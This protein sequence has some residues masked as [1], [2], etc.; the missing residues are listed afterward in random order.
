MAEVATPSGHTGPADAGAK[1]K[2][3]TSKPER[4]DE[5]EY[6]KGLALKEKEH[7]AKQDALVRALKSS[8]SSSAH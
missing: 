7:K 2:S 6:K 5:E 8:T 4:P 1:S 3:S